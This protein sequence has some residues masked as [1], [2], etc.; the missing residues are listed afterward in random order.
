MRFYRSGSLGMPPFGIG[1]EL[2]DANVVMIVRISCLSI[3]NINDM[4]ALYSEK[5]VHRPCRARLSPR[6]R[7]VSHTTQISEQPRH[8]V[9]TTV[10]PARS[11]VDVRRRK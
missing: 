7:V 2:T 3:P 4:Q 10:D 1:P 5:A 11:I 8:K 6:R 9:L